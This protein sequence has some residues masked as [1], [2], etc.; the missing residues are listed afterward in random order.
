MDTHTFL[1]FVL[2]DA[3]LNATARTL[4]VDPQNDILLSPASYWEIAIKIGLRKYRLPGPFQDFMQQQITLNQ[5]VVLPITV[6]HAAVV[7]TLPPHHRDPFDRLLIAQAMVEQVPIVRRGHGA[8][9]LSGDATLVMPD[10]EDGAKRPI[11]RVVPN[12]AT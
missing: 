5:F 9:R 11:A 8:R 6:A 12:S 10:A 7:A 3:S 2:N 1:W 4:I